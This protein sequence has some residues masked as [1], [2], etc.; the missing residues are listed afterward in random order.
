MA[1]KTAI[2]GCTNNRKCSG[3][4]KRAMKSVQYVLRKAI[5]DRLIIGLGPVLCRI[6]GCHYL[7]AEAR[8]HSQLGC[9]PLYIGLRSNCSLERYP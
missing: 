4:S 3:P 8:V 6:A 5:A 2:S 7:G 9:L 1:N